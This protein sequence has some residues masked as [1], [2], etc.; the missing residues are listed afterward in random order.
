VDCKLNG[1]KFKCRLKIPNSD[2][3]TYY[4]L[5]ENRSTDNVEYDSEGINFDAVLYENELNNYEK[6]IEVTY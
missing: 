2:I 3:K 5:Y 6:Y 1:K 4:N